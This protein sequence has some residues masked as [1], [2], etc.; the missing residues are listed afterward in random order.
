LLQLDLCTSLNVGLVLYTFAPPSTDSFVP[1]QVHG[2]YASDDAAA[3]FQSVLSS[4][5]FVG[6]ALELEGNRYLLSSTPTSVDAAL[7]SLASFAWRPLAARVA[8]VIPCNTPVGLEIHHIPDPACSPPEMRWWQTCE[9]L[10]SMRVQVHALRLF[11]PYPFGPVSSLAFQQTGYPFSVSLKAK[12]S[13]AMDV[14][15]LAAIDEV[16][17]VRHSHNARVERI[18]P[19]F[20]NRLSTSHPHLRPSNRGT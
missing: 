10:R 2:P 7:A 13:D 14:K 17:H 15:A 20:F 1:V 18:L 11:E 4:E 5:S 6:R 19:P 16:S 8:I 9:K 12:S 3:M